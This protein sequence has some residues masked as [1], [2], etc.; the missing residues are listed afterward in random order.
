[1]KEFPWIDIAKQW[2]VTKGI[3]FLTHFAVFL[4]LLLIGSRVIEGIVRVADAALVRTPRVR[5]MLRT[6]AVNVLRKTLWVVLLMIALPRIGIEIGP[7]V[8]GLGVMGFVAGFA[9]QES[10]SNLAA[11][12]MILLNE[13]FVAGDYIE[14]GGHAGS[15][16][17][18]NMMATTMFTGDN[19][20]IMIPNRVIWGSSIVNY[21]K[22][23]TRRVDMTLGVGYST[24][25]PKACALIREIVE[26]DARVLKG[27]APVIELA[28][29][30][31]S[32]MNIV[33]RPWVNRA[34][35]WDFKFEF[36]RRIK[37]AFDKNGIEIPF[38]QMDVHM[39]KS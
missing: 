2:A 28:E 11:G 27:P 36:N 33:V 19:R 38:P 10:L 34:D 39:A 37:E 35:Y 13:P 20:V 25:I 32:S 5:P 16:Q 8:A 1:M 23:R 4:V 9:F 17:E 30:G 22:N 6:F 21:S 18:L 15:V 3:A 31:D 12:I 24:D 29:F 14:A 7:L 26:S